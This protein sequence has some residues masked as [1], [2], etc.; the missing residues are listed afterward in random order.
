MIA[1]PYQKTSGAGNTFVVIDGKDLPAGID[2]PYLAQFACSDNREHGGADGLIVVLGIDGSDFEMKYYNRDG[3]TGM[4]CGNG[5]RCAV[6]FAAEH[7]YVAT[8]QDVSFVNA[9]VP[10]HAQLT[11]RGVRVDF[12]DPREL[13]IAVTLQLDN[14]LQPGNTPLHYSYVDVGTPHVVL[15]VDEVEGIQMDLEDN[16]DIH[17]VDVA[18]WGA[19]IRNHPR[20]VEKGVNVNF[21]SLLPANNGIQLRTYER[22]VEAETGACG[23]GAIASAIVTAFRHNLPCPINVIPTSGS[24]LWIDFQRSP[25]G[26][27]QNVSLEGGADI[28]HEGIL[29][30]TDQAISQP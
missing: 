21:V 25:Q 26:I 20:F 4:M 27:V 7:N 17:T 24:P 28:L 10:Y 29:Q 2:Y 8:E 22:G 6:R 30:L 13:Q 16:A 18:Q 5:G 3:S 23:T 19:A 1:I 12:P 9:G 15:F 14:P 11:E